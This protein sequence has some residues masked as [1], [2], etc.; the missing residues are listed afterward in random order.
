MPIIAVDTESRVTMWNPAAEALFGW[1]ED[2]VISQPIP[3]IPDHLRAEAAAMHT[4]LLSGETLRGIEVLRRRRNGSLVTIS[5]SAAPIRDAS[6]RVK[7]ILGF[8]ADITE[9]K[10]AE[11]ALRK[12]E[13]C[14]LYTSRCV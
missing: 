2:E 4:R 5:L 1:N 6:R 14:L 9:Q 7:G 8:M 11:E 12:A 3:I 13:D 10:C